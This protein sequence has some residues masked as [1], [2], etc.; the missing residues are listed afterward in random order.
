MVAIVN[1]TP[2]KRLERARVYSCDCIK[3]DPPAGRLRMVAVQYA[4]CGRPSRLFVFF[5]DTRRPWRSLCGAW[6]QLRRWRLRRI[7][8]RREALRLVWELAGRMEAL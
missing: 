4:V 1:D 8:T 3:I 6:R 5:V 7:V 2:Q